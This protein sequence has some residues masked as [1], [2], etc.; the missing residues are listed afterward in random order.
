M[1]NNS[2]N[3]VPL[4]DF[5]LKR[6]LEYRIFNGIKIIGKI[7]SSLFRNLISQD[8][9]RDKL[10]KKNFSTNNSIFKFFKGKQ[11]HCPHGFLLIS[12][13]TLS[14]WNLNLIDAII[15]H[16][17]LVS[18]ETISG[19]QYRYREKEEGKEKKDNY[20][21]IWCENRYLTRVWEASGC[22]FIEGIGEF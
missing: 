16:F 18:V 15:L 14:F 12:S 5:N 11:K 8:D 17:E 3:T 4:F 21:T 7:W 22:S 10:K 1:H 13:W 2:S 19:G 6:I 20:R 9:H